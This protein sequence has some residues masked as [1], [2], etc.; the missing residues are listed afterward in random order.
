M[1][2]PAQTKSWKSWLAGA[3]ALTGLALAPGAPAWAQ[4]GGGGSGGSGG[5]GNQPGGPGSVPQQ[6][7][8]QPQGVP[9]A[10]PA[11]APDVL[12]GDLGGVRSRLLNEGVNLQLDYTAEFAGNVSGER[13]GVDYAHQIAF[14]AD[15][16]WERLA[17]IPGFNTHF[18]AI[19]RAGRNLSSDYLG[20]QIAQAQETYGAGFNMGVH[21]V[22]AYIEQKLLDDRL[23]IAV[24]HWPL[25]T[26]FAT[27]T[28]S[29]I[30]IS[31]TPGCGNPRVLDNQAAGTNWPQSSW[32]GRVRFRITP[33]VYVQTGAWEVTPFPAGGRSGFAWFQG[34]STGAAFPVEVGWEPA[35]GPNRLTGHYKV[36]FLY[37]TSTY[38]DLLY[39]DLGQPLPLN[40]AIPAQTHSGRSTAY[41]VV[42]QM[43][44]RHGPGK[45]QGLMFLVSGALGSTNTIFNDATAFATLVD[46]GIIPSRPN[47]TIQIAAGWYGS[48]IASA[49]FRVCSCNWLSRRSTASPVRSATSTCSR[50]AIPPTSIAA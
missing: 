5:P 20:D 1:K 17:G 14:S 29:C 47:D 44:V 34:K 36:G 11:Q 6:T 22:Y 2:K 38:A 42:D 39:N 16:D 18:V 26:D 40:P 23:N 50:R 31:L 10:P 37:D 25:L 8:Q 24:G 15:I 43:L 28:L 46:T 49:S 21:L 13:R 7:L 33:D 3:A 41:F 48:R 27:S 4:A 12:L 9:A 45:D 30:A 19:N 35:F 32:G